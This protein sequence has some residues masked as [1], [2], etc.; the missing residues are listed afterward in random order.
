LLIGV[1]MPNTPKPNSTLFKIMKKRLYSVRLKESFRRS[2][3]DFTRERKMPFRKVVLFMMSLSRRSLQVDLTAF[4][5]SFS[6]GARNITSSAF[7]QNRKKIDPL[8]FKDLLQT[9]NGEFYTDNDARVLLWEGMRLLATDGSTL[10]LPGT[11]GLEAVYGRAANQ[12]KTTVVSARCSVLY[13]VLNNLV[14]D[15]ALAPFLTGERELARQHLPHCGQGD[16]VIYD[17]GYPGLELMAEV[18]E[19]GAHFLM[20]CKRDHNKQVVDFIG[21]DLQTLTVNTTPSRAVA[22][23]DNGEKQPDL[24]MRMVKVRL[25][26]GELEILLTSLLDEQRW[27]TALFKELYHKR[28]GVESF[29]NVVKNIV[30]VEQF[31]GHTPLVIQQDFYCALLMCNIHSLLVSEAQDELPIKHTGRKL[32]YKINNNISFGYMKS[33]LL[34]ILTDEDNEKMMASLKDLF[35]NS[36]VPIRPGRHFPRNTDKYKTR[37]KPVCLTNSR[38]AL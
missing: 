38:P 30:R 21:S 2:S 32:A 14:I 11:P 5:R 18:L 19:S 34:R 35:L 12:H 1:G 22:L 24:R 25:D 20:R 29:Y 27:P 8:L 28:W 31:T 6:E 7:N 4:M 10:I 15:G 17:R 36:T 33:E 9:L 37:S 13:D 26:T 16:L 23:T 3:K